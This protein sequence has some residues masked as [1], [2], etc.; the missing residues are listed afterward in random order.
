VLLLVLLYAPCNAVYAVCQRTQG[1]RRDGKVPHGV[2]G[3]LFDFI[4]QTDHTVV[5]QVSCA[6]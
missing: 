4:S 3:T 6:S 2:V 5:A 1:G